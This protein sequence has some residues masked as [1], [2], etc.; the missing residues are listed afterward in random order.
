MN[1][2]FFMLV[3]YSF[4]IGYTSL[5]V[6]MLCGLCVRGKKVQEVVVV[7]EFYMGGLIGL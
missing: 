4:L 2:I 3:I 6:L 1:V 5:D 7:L